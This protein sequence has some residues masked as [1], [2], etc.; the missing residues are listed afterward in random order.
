MR[1]L[2]SFLLLSGLLLIF[3]AAASAQVITW[4]Q[5]DDGIS[6][7]YAGRPLRHDTIAV[8]FTPPTQCKILAAK[9]QFN[10]GHGGGA[11]VFIWRP[12]ADFDPANYPDYHFAGSPAP[13]T[14]L[15]LSW[16]ANPI[17]YNFNSLGGWQ[18]LTFATYGLTPDMLDVG[19]S[20]FFVGYVLTGGATNPY[21]PAI[22]LDAADEPPF[23]SLCY[24]TE[25]QA[26][27]PGES[28]WWAFGYDCFV[29]AQVDMYG[30]PPPV[31]SG[32][33]DRPDTY[34]PGP[35]PITAYIS[36]MAQGGGQGQVTQAQMHYSVM[37]GDWVTV[38]MTHVS[39]STY[40]AIIPAIPQYA[41]V[42]YYVEA[43][44]NAGHI[45]ITPS[46]AGYNFSYLV[47]TDG[48]H[49]LLVND[50]AA[51]GQLFYTT[52]L[53]AAYFNHYDK[54]IINP[55]NAND[56]GFPGSD[57]INHNI[58]ST[59]LWFNGTANTGSLPDSGADL[60][61]NPVC[62][63]MNAGGN[64]FL[65]SSDYLG[66]GLTGD[67]SGYWTEF[68]S[69]A[70][71]TF[72]HDY[73]KV[74]AGWSDAHLG[75]SGESMDTVYYGVTGDPISGPFTT[76]FQDHP[77]PNYNDY[78]YPVNGSDAVTCFHTQIDDEEAGIR[79]SGTY[80]MVFLPW[81]LEAVDDTTISDGILYSILNYF[82]ETGVINVPTPEMPQTYAL[83]QNF[84]NPFNPSTQIRFSLPMTS[85]VELTVY[86]L[87]NQQVARL[88]N[89]TLT[90]G[91]HQVTWDA[92]QFASGIYFYK[93]QADN[94]VQTRKMV[95]VK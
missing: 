92:N 45:A 51:D 55:G 67:P 85:K 81:V 95:L 72:V 10:T 26:P 42:N 58:Y 73:L 93:L 70:P 76:P 16:G 1:K 34:L 22:F 47:P 40:T 53:D 54:W 36:D 66:K 15:G 69:T 37:M 11:Q 83:Q 7:A 74:G 56:Q 89:G 65:T 50:M 62:Q 4:L 61:D 64:F 75:G 30:D 19:D 12:K 78:V 23:N 84:P 8:L 52:A 2:S 29:R 24:L 77:S 20:T 32:L 44:D 79:Y 38:D 88:V 80:K 27:N 46:D 13:T 68:T 91:V 31:I 63:F 14:P 59:I 94:F 57:V 41:F 21:D 35:Y 33:V 6:T 9:F 82:G 49:I 18:T 3:A 90:A 48:A 39:D 86:N 28:G 5:N 25:P 17:P 60:S 87:S 71:G 43:H